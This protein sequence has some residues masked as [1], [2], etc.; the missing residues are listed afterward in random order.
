METCWPRLS[1]SVR[2]VVCLSQLATRAELWTRKAPKARKLEVEHKVKL[3]EVKPAQ[4]HQFA[5]QRWKELQQCETQVT[6]EQRKH[7]AEVEHKRLAEVEHNRLAEVEQRLVEVEEQDKGPIGQRKGEQDG[8][9]MGRRRPAR[10]RHR[11]HRVQRAA[12]SSQR[13]V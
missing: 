9:A 8:K 2:C 4:H 12:R 13:S 5:Q 1:E 6:V 3:W 11:Y 7:L 10:A